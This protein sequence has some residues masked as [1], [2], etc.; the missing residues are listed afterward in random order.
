MSKKIFL[1]VAT[2]VALFVI[3]EIGLRLKGFVPK[4][5]SKKSLLHVEPNDMVAIDSVLG[6]KLK[7]GR[8]KLQQATTEYSVT[9]DSSGHRISTHNS[10]GSDTLKPEFIFLGGPSIFGHGVNDDETCP[11]F[12]QSRLPQFNV[13]NMAMLHYGIAENY[14]QL[15]HLQNIRSGD[16]VVYVYHSGHDNRGRRLNQKLRNTENSDIPLKNYQYLTIDSNLNTRLNEYHHASIPFSSHSSVIYWLENTY[17][18]NLNKGD[19]SHRIA[20]KAILAM[21]NWCAQHNCKFVLVYW[22]PDK[23]A[24]ETLAFCKEPN[25]SALKIKGDISF[26]HLSAHEPIA[27]ANKGFADSL[28][29]RFTAAGLIDTA[30]TGNKQ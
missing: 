28:V 26:K 20:E 12:L 29:S 22:N 6:F 23:Y 7:P 5:S 21:H 4:D 19:D 8:Y 3:S 1:F 18:A 2:L 27:A 11:F 24:N 30:I 15:T 13:R 16:M 17:N 14:V 9:I 25:V 10:A